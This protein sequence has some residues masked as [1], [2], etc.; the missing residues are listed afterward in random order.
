MSKRDRELESGANF[1]SAMGDPSSRQKQIV[2]VTGV[3]SV[4]LELELCAR[5]H[6]LGTA[7]DLGTA[8]GADGRMLLVGKQ[9][10]ALGSKTACGASTRDLA[11]GPSKSW[12]R[13]F[14]NLRRSANPF[15]GGGA[16]KASIAPNALDERA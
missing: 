8:V 7:Q 2:W 3:A 14:S 12:E 10:S 4:R 9:D 6:A 1:R 5:S 16:W 13:F 11:S 15:V